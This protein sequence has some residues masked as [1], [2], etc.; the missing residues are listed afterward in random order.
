MATDGEYQNWTSFTGKDG[1]SI[2]SSDHEFGGSWNEY[3]TPDWQIKD[4]RAWGYGSCMPGTDLGSNAD[5]YIE[6]RL[7]WLGVG[8]SPNNGDHSFYLTT[9]HNGSNQYECIFENNGTWK[10]RKLVSATYTNLTQGTIDSWSTNE[11]RTVGFLVEGTEL[12][13]YVDGVQI[14]ETATDSSLSGGDGSDDW[15]FNTYITTGAGGA[16]TNTGFHVDWATFSSPPIDLETPYINETVLAREAAVVER[17]IRVFGMDF[18]I[19]DEGNEISGTLKVT[20]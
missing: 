9:R 6:A 8:V 1:T 13:A 16:T 20:P 19:D 12:S 14:G 11:E 15:G 2:A 4:N 17:R 3:G 10:L 7:R 5:S 18:E